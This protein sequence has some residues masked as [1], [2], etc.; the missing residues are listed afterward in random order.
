MDAIRRYLVYNTKGRGK[1]WNALKREAKIEPVSVEDGARVT[2]DGREVFWWAGQPFAQ[3][4]EA[5]EHTRQRSIEA[6]KRLRNP[7][8]TAPGRHIST[9]EH[10]LCQ[11]V[12]DGQLC[13]GDLKRKGIC[14][15]CA[16]GRQGVTALE[17]CDV[18]G[19]ETAV[20]ASR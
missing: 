4:A 10:T 20:M 5:H 8:R 16:L 18:C 14:P 7:P 1:M 11:A 2:G 12:I 13:G 6:S 19:R 3:T 17:T 9:E 15:K